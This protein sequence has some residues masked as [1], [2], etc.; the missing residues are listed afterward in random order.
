ME[1]TKATPSDATQLAV[2]FTQ[3]TDRPTDVSTLTN[4]LK[5]MA[6]NPNY[7]ILVAKEGDTVLG[8]A[9]GIVCQD[10]VQECYSVMLVEN[11]V[12]DDGHQH[13]GIGKAL[14]QALDEI[15]CQ[16]NCNTM[17][18]LSSTFRTGAHAFYRSLGYSSENTLGFKKPLH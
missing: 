17:V 1:I 14:I 9:M 16:R 10:F 8:T 6:F 7:Y 5:R 2:L 18:L 13:R 15:A 3:L 11:V 12:V 4:A